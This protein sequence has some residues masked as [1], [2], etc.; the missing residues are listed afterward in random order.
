MAQKLL[1]LNG[2]EHE[3]LSMSSGTVSSYEVTL[4]GASLCKITIPGTDLTNNI[5]PVGDKYSFNLNNDE[6]TLDSLFIMGIIQCTQGYPVIS[7]ISNII[8]GRATF[9]ILNMGGQGVNAED[10]T[11]NII[12]T[13]IIT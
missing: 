12:L 11:T 1:T 9:E 5:L 3:L 10:I 7:R 13:L 6:I 8:S 4:H 2:V